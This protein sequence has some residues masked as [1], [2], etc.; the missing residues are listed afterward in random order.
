MG[1]KHE[2]IVHELI[3]E[4]VGPGADTIQVEYRDGYEEICVLKGGAGFEIARWPSSGR[5]AVS[6]CKE[7][8][9]LRR[10]RAKVTISGAEYEIRTR[11]YDHFGEQT[12]EVRLRRVQAVKVK[13][14]A[15]SRGSARCRCT[16]RSASRDRQQFP[17]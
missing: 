9:D 11:T 5:R 12:L 7:L 4:A 6:L 1:S 3:A 16:L 17:F 10:K 15:D 2:G 14:L 8:H 13:T